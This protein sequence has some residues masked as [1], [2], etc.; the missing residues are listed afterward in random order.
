MPDGSFVRYHGW[1]DTPSVLM[2]LI[3]SQ[4]VVV[5]VKRLKVL[6][7]CRELWVS[8]KPSSQSARGVDIPP[9]TCICFFWLLMFNWGNTC[10]K[11]NQK[12]GFCSRATNVCGGSDPRVGMK[13]KRLLRNDPLVFQACELGLPCK[14]ENSIQNRPLLTKIETAW[15]LYHIE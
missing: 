10:C 1:G 15:S 12:Y 2:N 13:G 14:V 11:G 3:R 6:A 5:R 9:T 8:G 7:T 4:C